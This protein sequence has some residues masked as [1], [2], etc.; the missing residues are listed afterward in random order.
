MIKIGV[1]PTP[2]IAEHC[3]T[4]TG[5]TLFILFWLAFVIGHN[6][7]GVYIP[8]FKTQVWKLSS[9]V[10]LLGALFVLVAVNGLLSREVIEASKQYTV[11]C[12]RYLDL[13]PEASLQ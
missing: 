2:S 13:A 4:I 8:T 7:L 10:V 1:L 3:S 11:H 12:Q 9:G 6:M 5:I